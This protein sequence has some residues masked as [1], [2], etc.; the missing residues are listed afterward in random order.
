MARLT[1]FELAADDHPIMRYQTEDPG[2]WT[3]NAR[4][5]VPPPEDQ[6]EEIEII[7]SLERQVVNEL[8]L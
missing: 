7:A 2:V 1:S 5:R 3:Q 6:A 4:D 8:R